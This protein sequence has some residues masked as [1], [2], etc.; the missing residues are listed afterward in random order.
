[1][2]RHTASTILCCLWEVLPLAELLELV[3]TV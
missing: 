3:A 2:Q 1:M